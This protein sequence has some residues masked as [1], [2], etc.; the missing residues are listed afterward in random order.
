MRV[1]IIYHYPALYRGPIFQL[2]SSCKEHKFTLIS[3]TKSPNDIKLIPLNYASLPTEKGGI[4]WS[5]IKNIW[6]TK[7]KILWQK[8][9]L[10]KVLSR[11]FDAFIFLGNPY[12]I[13]TWIS[14]I[15][16]RL[17]KRPVFFWAHGLIHKEKG[18][19]KIVKYTFLKLA[20]GLLLYGDRAKQ[21]LTEEGF[22]EN[23]LHVIYNS[24][25][26]NKQLKL[27]EKLNP[28][29]LKNIKKS[30]FKKNEL[31]TL[32]FIGRLTPQKK[33]EQI[34]E[35]LKVLKDQEIFY[36]LIFVG[37]GSEKNN[38]QLLSEKNNLKENIVFYGACYDEELISQLIGASD[39][40]ISPGEVGLTAIHSLSY[41]TPVITH[42]N[43]DKQ[44]PE[45]EAVTPNKTGLFF[46][47][48][49]V[50][51]LAEKIKFWIQEHT[52][53]EQVQQDCYSVIDQKY[54]PYYQR[55]KINK[56]VT[57]QFFNN[58]SSSDN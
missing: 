7:D 53:R 47:Q 38:L 52:N 48:D 51:D 21:L 32:I 56:L 42:N 24:L 45:F 30:L 14:A 9:L 36:N 31:P 29:N 20:N 5:F 58:E 23:T 11:D 15:I 57:H 44:M 35:A 50:N 33:L 43:F 12:F 55:N 39:I 10:R 27:R 18:F 37:E 54:N 41:G 28:I 19:Q 2:L 13:S 4:N 22:N 1:A 17:R 6:I 16:L 25:D 46:E 34:I 8:G 26:Y 49:N 3:D 40:C